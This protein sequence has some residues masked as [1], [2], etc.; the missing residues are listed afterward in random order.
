MKIEKVVLI[1]AISMTVITTFATAVTSTIAALNFL[2][3]QTHFVA[4]KLYLSLS[5]LI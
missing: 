4:Y 2:N 3:T 5:D 1:I